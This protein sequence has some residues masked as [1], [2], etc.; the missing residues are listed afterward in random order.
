[1]VERR[2]FGP[3]ALLTLLAPESRRVARPGQFVMVAVPGAQF[4]LRRP[5]SLHSVDGERLRLLVEARGDG[6]QAAGRGRRRR[7]PGARRPAGH[8][9]PAG[10]RA[11]RAARR[12]RHRRG[13][14]AVP[15][16]RAAR[17]RACRDGR[18]RL[19]RPAA[20]RASPVPSRSPT[21][22]WP[23][24]TAPSAGAAPPSSWRARWAR[25]RRRAC[26]PAA[27]RRCSPRCAPGPPRPACRATRR[28]K[29]TWPAAPAP[30][31]AASCRPARATCASAAKARCSRSTCW[32]SGPRAVRRHCGGDAVNVPPVAE[33]PDLSVTLA[34]LR[35]RT[36]RPERLRHLRRPRDRAPLRGGRPE[37]F[38]F[39][40]YVPKTVTLEARAGN[41]PPR[42]TETAVGHDQ[43][44]RPGEPGH[45]RLARRPAALGGLPV[46]VL[47]SIG[48]SRPEDYLAVVRRIEERLQA[49]RRPAARR[50]LRAERVLPERG[51]GRPGDRHRP[52][53][54][55]RPHRGRAR[56]SPGASS[57]SSSRRTSPTSWP[58]RG[59]PPTPAPTPCRSST[60]S[61]AGARS[62][63]PC[64]RFWAIAPAASAGRPS[65]RSRCAWSAEVAG[66]LDVPII[67]MGGIVTGRDVLE[68]IACGAT[69][70]AVGAANFAAS[71]AGAAHRRRA[72]AEMRA[73]GLADLGG[74]AR[75]GARPLLAAS[76]PAPATP[77]A[78]VANA[79]A[80]VAIF[81]QRS[82]LELAGR[83]S[84]YLPAD[85]DAGQAVQRRPRA[86]AR[87][88]HGRAQAR[89]P[90]A[91]PARPA[92]GRPQ[93][94][95]ASPSPRCCASRPSSC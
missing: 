23:P 9:L 95:R 74:G 20:R 33:P 90:R 63:R 81:G 60:R 67:G 4:R 43:R 53:R 42:V 19:S 68:F 52:G 37:P 59:P 88:A 69:A 27:P 84:I 55:G 13:A 40:A 71:D 31:T 80:S 65:S 12:R 58:S 48:G 14:A 73:R 76:A 1:M 62:A 57:S 70:V 86:L 34:G 61:G 79:A 2:S 17:P 75:Q 46:P 25:G 54:D 6:T 47:V 10:R 36:P 16:R 18:L 45:R 56:R 15:R 30:A 32:S 21:S 94:R 89:Q 41:P 44:R 38:P 64:G 35:S 92:Q 82:A 26:S 5:L 91:Q 93:A 7:H 85:A 22:G 3:Y 24:T 49:R 83:R 87:P 51:E 50:R 77:G 8:G 29:P 66:A 39:A 72:R 78:G 28:S 11:R